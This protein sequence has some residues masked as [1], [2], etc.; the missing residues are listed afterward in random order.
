[1]SEYFSLPLKVDF[2]SS[3]IIILFS[4]FGII[5]YKHKKDKFFLTI[6]LLIQIVIL[7][8]LFNIIKHFP[9]ILTIC[10]LISVVLIII[11]LIFKS[12]KIFTYV[13][14]LIHF[15]SLMQL[16]YILKIIS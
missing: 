4:I 3:I 9:N 8:V 10:S 15:S 12:D 14:F 2:L 5:F 16:L 1:M 6:I 13:S 7:G 11:F